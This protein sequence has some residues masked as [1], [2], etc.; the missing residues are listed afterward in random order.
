MKKLNIV[1]RVHSKLIGKRLHITIR[2]KG[3]L[4]IR[5]TKTIR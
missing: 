3:G 2:F 1:K 4:V 5:K